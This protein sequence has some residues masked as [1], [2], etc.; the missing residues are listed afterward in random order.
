MH[1]PDCL[2]SGESLSKLS[3]LR[4]FGGDK[5]PRWKVEIHSVHFP[6][7]HK[8]QL[9]THFESIDTHLECMVT[10]TDGK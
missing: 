10:E 8:L 6:S 5:L 7:K 4:G 1:S 3:T 9:F 2:N